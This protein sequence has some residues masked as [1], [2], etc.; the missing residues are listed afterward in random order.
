MI[1]DLEIAQLRQALADCRYNQRQ[2]ARQLGLTYDQLRGKL[3]KYG[4]AVMAP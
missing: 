4:T 1:T 2:A 3:K